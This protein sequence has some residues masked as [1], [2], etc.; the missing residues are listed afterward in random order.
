[1]P[2]QPPSF[3]IIKQRSL[4][5]GGFT[6]PFTPFKNV[7]LPTQQMTGFETVILTPGIVL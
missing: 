2:G 7:K 5:A 4:S 1:M 3:A 6:L